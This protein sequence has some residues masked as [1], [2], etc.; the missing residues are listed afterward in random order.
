MELRTALLALNDTGA[1]FAVR[2]AHFAEEG[3][4]VASRRVMEPA[5]GSAA[6]SR[7]G[8]GPWRYGCVWSP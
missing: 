6:S 3:G 5:R 2:E 7:Q 8:S 4:L 1:P